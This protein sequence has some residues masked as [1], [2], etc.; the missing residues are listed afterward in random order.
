[1]PERGVTSKSARRIGQEIAE[2][3]HVVAKA[4]LPAALVVWPSRALGG[5]F[6]PRMKSV[7][8]DTEAVGDVEILL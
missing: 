1:M 8:V 2:D 4:C 7:I 3:D 5:Y 6:G